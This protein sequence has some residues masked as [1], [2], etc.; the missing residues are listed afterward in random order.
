MAEDTGRQ[1]DDTGATDDEEDD[2]T[3]T[4]TKTTEPEM[5]TRD[6]LNRVIAQRDR[7]KARARK[8]EEPKG[9]ESDEDDVPTKTKTN[10]ADARA[11]AKT[12]REL[13]AAD[14]KLATYKT[15]AVTASARGA[16]ITAG[17][18]LPAEPEGRKAALAKLT[19][20]IDTS[21]L[22]FDGGEI[23]G[24]DDQVAEIKRDFPDLFTDTAKKRTARIK[25]SDGGR[26]GKGKSSAER[27]TEQ[28]F[29]A[30][31]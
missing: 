21:E 19:R 31:D 8:L 11:A 6:E 14:Q 9:G 24:L 20:L 18:K 26:N 5:V 22:D 3:G 27:L 1:D 2:D 7:A 29:G 17:A 30:A 28:L 23:D 16:F 25:G 13:A 4:E 15:A 10:P 12:A